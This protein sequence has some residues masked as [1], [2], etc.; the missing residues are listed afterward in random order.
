MIFCWLPPERVPAETVAD[1]VRASYAL[2]ESLGVFQDG[3]SS[4]TRPCAKRLAEVVVENEV[5]GQRK[6]QNESEALSIGR[7]EGDVHFMHRA[8]VGPCDVLAV[9]RD[10]RAGDSAGA[11]R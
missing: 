11:G 8:R 3:R 7:H 2:D 6:G 10:F 4:R 1:G 5:V 9:E